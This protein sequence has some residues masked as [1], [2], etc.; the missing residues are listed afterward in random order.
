LHHGRHSGCLQPIRAIAT[1]VAMMGRSDIRRILAGAPPLGALALSGCVRG[2]PSFTLF[3]SFFPAWMFCAIFGVL[4][5]IAARV[6]FVALG[7]ADLLPFQ[8]FVCTSI[9]VVFAAI[10]WL[11]WFGR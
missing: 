1:V 8:L 4:A 2:A 3:G 6:T 9:G 10:G 7:K 11:V 5:A